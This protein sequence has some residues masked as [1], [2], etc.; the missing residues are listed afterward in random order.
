[1][2]ILVAGC[3]GPPTPPSPSPTAAATGSPTAS[4]A[5][6]RSPAAASTTP[7]GDASPS[8]IADLGPVDALPLRTLTLVCE[9]WPSEPIEG[10]IDCARAARLALAAVGPGTAALIRRI[11]VGFGD[12]CDDLSGG[13]PNRT[14]VTG[15]VLLRT[16]DADALIVPVAVDPDVGLQAWPPIPGRRMFPPPFDPP[17]AAAPVVVPDAPRGVRDRDP[18]PFCGDE[19]VRG[20]DDFEIDMRGCFLN[21]VLAAVP[22]ELISR[23]SSTEGGDVVTVYRF[24]GDG[25]LHQLVDDRG[26]WSASICGI[27]PVSLKVVFLPAGD[28][29]TVKL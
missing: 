8:P 24:T 29:Q 21:G 27:A 7:D 4:G 18:L 10:S 1:M 23:A 11:D 2:T 14:P 16:A 6:P 19:D 25:P 17:P 15:W 13:C 5:S 12:W 26:H 22:V 28:C 9:P 3:T 20:T